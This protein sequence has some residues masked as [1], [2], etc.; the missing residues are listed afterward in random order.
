MAKHKVKMSE[1]VKSTQAVQASAE[2]GGGGGKVDYGKLGPGLNRLLILP[3]WDGKNLMKRVLVHQVWKGRKP[4][5]TATS[6]RIVEGEDDPIMDAGF[7]L[8][9]KFEESTDKRK[10]ILWKKYMPSD[11]FC[12]NALNL[13]DKNPTPKVYRLPNIAMKFLCDEVGEIE[14]GDTIWDLE[15]GFPLIIKGNGKN[16][17]DRRYILAKWSKKPAALVSEGRVDEDA[18]L[19]GLHDLDTLQPKVSEEKL[20]KV[21]TMLKKQDQVI[22][23]GGDE[24]EE[25]DDAEDDNDEPRAKKKS[26]A[27]K[28]RDDDD[29]ESDEADGDDDDDNDFEDDDDKPAKKKTKAKP[30]RASRDDDDDE[31]EDSADEDEEDDDDE[32][33]AKKK[34]KTKVKAK[35]KRSRDEDDDDE[36]DSDDEEDGLDDEALDDDEDEEDEKPARKKPAKKAAAGL[37][38]KR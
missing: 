8:K 1:V 2:R 13:D 22:L 25:G 18:I 32:P 6:P 24:D 23:S 17:N 29:D 38:K 5:M 28:S 11:T 4:I 27:K 21:L 34:T 7:R 3:P 20:K 33:R 35:A 15:K 30:K 26:K 16:G 37:R 14:D 10:Q 19:E 12:V 36:E 31:E 9:E